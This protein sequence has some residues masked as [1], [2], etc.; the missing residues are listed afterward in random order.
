MDKIKLISLEN[1]IKTKGNNVFIDKSKKVKISKETNGFSSIQYDLIK[2]HPK[3]KDFSNSESDL[4]FYSN[5]MTFFENNG[6]A[7]NDNLIECYHMR[8]LALFQLKR[9][10]E[11]IDDVNKIILIK[12]YYSN[13][14]VI[15]SKA[16]VELRQIYQA[17][18]GIFHACVLEEF[19]EPELNTM[20]M[21]LVHKI[22]K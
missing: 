5:A 3:N 9:F 20:L 1:A 19:K 18:D 7:S 10:E 8:S 2:L 12:P 15:R 21:Y 4:K 22:G 11:C 13:A 16:Y 14:F 6:S 17:Y